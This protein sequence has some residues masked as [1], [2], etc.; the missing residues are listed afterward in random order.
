MG[1][2]CGGSIASQFSYESSQQMLLLS[3]CIASYSYITKETSIPIVFFVLVEF[4]IFAP[5]SPQNT[6]SCA[7]SLDR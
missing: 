4:Y 5:Y 3:V 7:F 6:I 1:Y 2:F